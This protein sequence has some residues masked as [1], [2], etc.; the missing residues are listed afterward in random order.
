M[1]LPHRQV[2]SSSI[3]SFQQRLAGML[4]HRGETKEKEKPGRSGLWYC[5][6]GMMET[7]PKEIEKQTIVQAAWQN[8]HAVFM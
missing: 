4:I 8:L 2:T 3:S 5:T 1:G 6:F 7:Q